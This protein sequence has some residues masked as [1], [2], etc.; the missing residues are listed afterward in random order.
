MTTEI[1]LPILPNIETIVKEVI[2]AEIKD[3]IRVWAEE[4]ALAIAKS[5]GGAPQLLTT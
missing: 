1:K 3:R 4:K 5:I 2:E